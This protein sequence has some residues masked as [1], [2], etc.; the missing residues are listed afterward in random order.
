MTTAILNRQ[1]FTFSRELEFFSEKELTTQIG[2]PSQYWLS[3]IIKELLDNALDACETAMVSPNITVSVIDDFIC[4]EDNGTGILPEVVTKILDFT[5][6]TSDKA[7]YC[8]PSRGQQGNALKTILAIPYVLSEGKKESRVVIE[9]CGI[10]HDIRVSLDAIAGKP[11]IE[12]NQ[13]EIVKTGGT[14]ISVYTSIGLETAK[15]IFLQIVIDFF[16]LSPHMLLKT[17]GLTSDFDNSA[18]TQDWHKWTP[19]EPTSP[20][21]YSLENIKKL[22]SAHI[23]LSRNGSGRDLTIREFIKQFRGLT[24]TQRQKRITDHLPDDIKRLSDLV[25]DDQRLN[26]ALVSS[27]LS[28]M[29]GKAD[30]CRQRC[31]E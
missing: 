26:E 23:A 6:R 15:P 5:M 25:V 28:Q 11:L 18:T 4:V 19:K 20:Y 10:R 9:S 24:S 7:V 8:S 27:L 16:V 12:H 17:H 22:I 13:M 21:W 30:Q 29:Q 3:V 2:L 31:W 1:T 14:K